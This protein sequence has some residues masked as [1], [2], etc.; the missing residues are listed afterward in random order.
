MG[1]SDD[2]VEKAIEAAQRVFRDA[3]INDIFISTFSIE[4]NPVDF[5]EECNCGSRCVG[6]TCVPYERCWVENGQRV[7]TR[8]HTRQCSRT[9]CNPC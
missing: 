2:L 9:A 6:W 5:N 3:G 7:C 1:V 4:D 8:G